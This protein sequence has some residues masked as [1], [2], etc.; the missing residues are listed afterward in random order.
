MLLPPDQ[1]R[2][3]HRA[4][5]GQSTT[6]Q[7]SGSPIASRGG[8]A[9]PPQAQPPQSRTVTSILTIPEW[10]SAGCDLLR[11]AKSARGRTD[12]VPA[13]TTLR[14][15]LPRS[16]QAAL[17]VGRTAQP[18]R[19][20]IPGYPCPAQSSGRPPGT[21]IVV[22]PRY[23]RRNGTWEANWASSSVV[24]RDRFFLSL[25]NTGTP[26]SG[27]LSVVCHGVRYPRC[28]KSGSHGQ[29][30]RDRRPTAPHLSLCKSAFQNAGF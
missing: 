18:I 24:P 16:S 19:G 22:L 15:G 5:H 21:G 20:R 14:A 13:P 12:I 4:G 27:F 17:T 1:G 10:Q 9:R 23:S 25:T 30:T 28:F 29:R 11:A 6:W 3:N 26:R 7:R 2:A 8:R